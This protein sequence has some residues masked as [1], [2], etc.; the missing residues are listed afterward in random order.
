MPVTLMDVLSQ[1]RPAAPGQRA[2]PARAPTPD[3]LRALA[4]AIESGSYR[5]SAELV[6]EAMLRTPGRPARRG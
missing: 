5:V 2:R 4:R 6:A 3:Q 1:L